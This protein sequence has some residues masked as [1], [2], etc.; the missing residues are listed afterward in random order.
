ME[1]G[2]RFSTLIRGL[3]RG[4]GARLTVDAKLGLRQRSD[5]G[6]AEGGLMISE[7]IRELKFK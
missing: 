1:Q 2:A 4:F 5:S 6:C 3:S 7:S